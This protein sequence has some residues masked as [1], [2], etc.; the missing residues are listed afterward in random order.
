MKHSPVALFLFFGLFPQAQALNLSELSG[1]WNQLET[2]S[3][4]LENAGSGQRISWKF[5]S[6]RLEKSI[7]DYDSD[8]VY[9]GTH[10]QYTVGIEGSYLVLNP[11]A[12]TE[13]E[14]RQFEEPNPGQSPVTRNTRISKSSLRYRIDAAAPN[15]VSLSLCAEPTCHQIQGVRTLTRELTNPTE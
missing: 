6:N 9:Q 12:A 8:G 14:Y 13:T 4:N 3:N 11:L 2:A 5:S 7:E 10:L 1:E 15:R